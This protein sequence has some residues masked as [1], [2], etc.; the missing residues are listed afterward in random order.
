VGIAVAVYRQSVSCK[1]GQAPE[2][3]DRSTHGDAKAT[4]LVLLRR[5]WADGLCFQYGI[6]SREARGSVEYPSTKS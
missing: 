3:D 4:T 6:V 1:H 5:R 2:R